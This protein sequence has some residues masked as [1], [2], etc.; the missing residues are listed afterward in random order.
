MNKGQI[1]KN[2]PSYFYFT[3]LTSSHQF[4]TVLKLNCK[5]QEHLN[6]FSSVFLRNI[7]LQKTNTQEGKRT[8]E[9]DFNQNMFFLYKYYDVP[10][11]YKPQH[12]ETVKKSVSVF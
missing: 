12:R 11:I 5:F 6:R 8:F 2:K 9:Y 10:E 4:L 3:I 7:I 1:Y